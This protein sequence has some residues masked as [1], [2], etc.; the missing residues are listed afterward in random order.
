VR[1]EDLIANPLAEMEKLYDRLQLGG[2]EG[3]RERFQDYFRS[4]K[5]YQTNRYPSLEPTLRDQ[6]ARRWGAVIRQYGYEPPS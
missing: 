2:F 3:V 4:T 6:I 1:Y 5:E